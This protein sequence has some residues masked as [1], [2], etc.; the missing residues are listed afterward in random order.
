MVDIPLEDVNSDVDVDY[1][2]EVDI[3]PGIPS[4]EAAIKFRPMPRR[5]ECV[6]GATASELL[7]PCDNLRQAQRLSQARPQLLRYLSSFIEARARFRIVELSARS[8]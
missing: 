1:A 5:R 6:Y 2:G 3:E 4:L 7:K 8:P